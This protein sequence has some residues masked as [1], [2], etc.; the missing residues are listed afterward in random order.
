MKHKPLCLV[1]SLLVFI[2]ALNWGLVGLGGFLNINFNLV[3]LALGGWPVVEN[4]VYLLVALASL[5]FV[6]G[7]FKSPCT[8]CEAKKG[9]EAPKEEAP[10]EPSEPEAPT[11]EEETPMGQ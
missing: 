5:I 10:A 9:E 6:I 7:F 1:V 2:G 8:T 3:D 4:I 11:Q